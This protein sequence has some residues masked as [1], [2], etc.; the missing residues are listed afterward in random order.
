MKTIEQIDK[1]KATVLYI[2]Q[3]FKEGVDYIHLFKIMYFAQQSHLVK[4]AVPI[5]EDIFV[6]RKHGPVPALTYKVLRCAEGKTLSNN[7]DLADFIKSVCISFKGGHQIVSIV[8][9]A[10]PDM[11]EFSKSDLSYLDNAI[12]EYGNIDTFQ[13]SDISHDKAYLIAKEESERTGEDV[14]IPMV[15]I[16]MAGGATKAMQEAIRNHQINKRELEWN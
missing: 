13:L 14:R 8:P 1:I 3:H 5:M 10:Y 9:G 2:L 12:K 15:N 16:A 11:D 6:A 4:Y 7:E